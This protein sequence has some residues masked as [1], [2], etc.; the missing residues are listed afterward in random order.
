MYTISVVA[1]VCLMLWAAIDYVRRAHKRPSDPVLATW[2]LMAVMMG[3]SFWMYWESPDKTWTGN[4]GVVAG[5]VNIAII[6]GGVV[7]AQWKYDTLRLAFNKVQAWC[8]FGGGVIVLFW[9]CTGN[10]LVSYV[11]VQCIALAA[12]FAT[13][14]KLWGAK[15]SSEPYLLWGVVLAANVVALYP[16]LDRADVYS[17]IYLGRAIPSTAI[18]LFL[19][20]RIKSRMRKSEAVETA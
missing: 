8:L 11:L 12:Y 9:L 7:R 13:V 4:I 18:V 16:A 17:W 20:Y 19:I 15:K 5:V 1:V 14:K 10:P 2:I 6:L 3:L